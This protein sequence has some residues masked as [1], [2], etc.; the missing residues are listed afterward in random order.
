MVYI[1]DLIE[2]IIFRRYVNTHI[3]LILLIW[4]VCVSFPL[5]NNG[6]MINFVNR[7]ICICL[8]QYYKGVIIVI[9]VFRCEFTPKRSTK[10]NIIQDIFNWRNWGTAVHYIII[11]IHIDRMYAVLEYQ[12]NIIQDL[13]SLFNYQKNFW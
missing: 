10:M 5:I 7:N 12:G 13:I 2:F 4:L 6:W 3:M 11:I 9:I 1:H 8:K